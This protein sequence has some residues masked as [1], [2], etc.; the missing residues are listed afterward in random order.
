M[1][2][3]LSPPCTQKRTS[4]RRHGMSAKCQKRKWPDLFDHLVGANLDRRRQIDPD[5]LGSL[6]VD[7]QLEFYGLFH[8]EIGGLRTVEYFGCIKAELTIVSVR[9]YSVG[10]KSACCPPSALIGQT[11]RIEQ[12][13]VSGSS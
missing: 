6:E 7:H 5:R 10:H 8:G 2:S 3:D 11:G 13:R 12:G 1:M 4:N 9:V